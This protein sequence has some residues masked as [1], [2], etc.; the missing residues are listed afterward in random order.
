[1]WVEPGRTARRPWLCVSLEL[2]RR[3]RVHLAAFFLMVAL[4][5]KSAQATEDFEFWSA[6]GASVRLSKDWTVGAEEILKFANGAG[7]LYLNQTD[8][9]FVYGG[10]ADWIDIGLNFKESFKEEDDGHWSRE[11]RPHL[12]ITLKNQVGALDVS[13]R[14]RLEYRDFEDDDDTWR[15]INQLKV[16][17][18][19]EFTRFKIRPYFA[20]QLYL[21]MEGHAFEK[22]R[23][24]S[25]ASLKLSKD[26]ESELYYVWQSGKSD[27]C[28][29]DLNAIGMQLKIAF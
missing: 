4:V 19:C 23:V 25:G 18:P 2:K 29:D 16:K 14:S 8:L 22:N 21:N 7:H 26:I 6:T 15:Y 13:D 1:M 3:K 9:G 11:N 12:N 17:L 5:G 27:G 10:L 24:Y 20:Y 28:W